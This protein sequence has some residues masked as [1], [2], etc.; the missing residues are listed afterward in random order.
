MGPAAQALRQHELF[1]LAGGELL[2]FQVELGAGEVQLPEYGHEKALVYGGG[3]GI[4]GQGAGQVGT[5]LG[6]IGYYE[7]RGKAETAAVLQRLPRQKLQQAGFP[8][9]VPAVQGDAL[10]PAQTEAQAGA[11]LSAAVCRRTVFQADE[12]LA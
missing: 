10:A 1:L 2:Q 4:G 7:P 11:D 5:V 9:A 6:H 3:A 12:L 8:A